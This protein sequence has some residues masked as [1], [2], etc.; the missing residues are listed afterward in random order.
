MFGLQKSMFGLQISMF[1]D[2]FDCFRTFID[3]FGRS[4]LVRDAPQKTL[5]FF[6]R[7]SARW[8]L[9]IVRRGR[10]RGRGRGVD[11]EFD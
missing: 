10:G 2:V 3:V 11:V 5:N 8:L 6:S 7:P 1:T 4:R 9:A